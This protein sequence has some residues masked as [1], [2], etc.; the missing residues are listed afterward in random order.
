M[1]NSILKMKHVDKL[2]GIGLVSVL[3]V[4]IALFLRNPVYYPHVIVETR[5]IAIPD[6][7]KIRLDFVY[8]GRPK[9]DECQATANLLANIVS[10]TCTACQVTVQRCSSK[11][12]AEYERLLSQEPVAMPTFRLPNGVVSYNS[13][14]AEIALSACQETERLT[15]TNKGNRANCYPANTARPLTISPNSQPA[16][17]WQAMFSLPILLLTS[18]IFAGYFIVR[19]VAWRAH[20][21]A[22]TQEYS[23]LWMNPTLSKAN[24]FDNDRTLLRL[25]K[26]DNDAL[27][28]AFDVIFSLMSIIVF[29]PF[30]LLVP[31]AIKLIDWRC[32][33]I[34]SIRAVGKGGR[35]FPMHKFSTMVSDADKVLADLLARD[36]AMRKEWEENH[37]LIND[38]RLLPVIGKFLRKFSI[39]ELPQLFNVLKGEMAVVGPRPI[40]PEEETKY[41]RVGIA[42][43]LRLRHSIRPGITGL[44][45]ISG[46]NNISYRERVL[47]DAHYLQNR[48]LLLDFKILL[49]TAVVVL[50]GIGAY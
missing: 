4:S 5:G 12:E 8:Q 3:V 32:P 34:V 35:L 23:G 7:A 21:R 13:P 26:L 45:Q 1:A 38:P 37:K 19:S 31:L 33:V 47:I 40:S 10:A 39:N 49:K 27:K 20:P 28:R 11:L 25:R 44:W 29:L 30:F 17:I 14:T 15:G 18:A 9:V 16:D 22:L 41:E 50:R 48:S 36:P 46:R 42:D 6:N 24:L 2:V 43:V